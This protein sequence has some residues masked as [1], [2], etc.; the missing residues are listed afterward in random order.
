[1]SASLVRLRDLRML[2][3]FA[4]LARRGTSG[5]DDPDPVVP[6]RKDYQKEAPS[7]RVPDDEGALL[8]LAVGGVGQHLCM[9]LIL[10]Q[11]PS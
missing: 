9:G 1:M 8:L 3:I 4:T 7:C 2:F 5:A 6:L 11:A 10:M